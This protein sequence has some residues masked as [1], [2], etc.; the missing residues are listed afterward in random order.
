[1]KVCSLQKNIGTC[2]F[3]PY[4]FFG[5]AYE[6]FIKF[7]YGSFKNS[8]ISWYC[9]A[10]ASGVASVT[11]ILYWGDNLNIHCCTSDTAP[12]Q[13]TLEAANI[14]STTW[15]LATQMGDLNAI[16][17]SKLHVHLRS[18]PAHGRFLF[19]SLCPSVLDK[20][21][22]LF[23]KNFDT[24]LNKLYTFLWDCESG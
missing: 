16:R 10:S 20:E 14:R 11:G 24:F 15:V 9:D 12:C 4:A 1:M 5:T 2:S 3:F 21:I 8:C 6:N 23:N 17:C 19:L 7:I 22:N 13:C 18:I